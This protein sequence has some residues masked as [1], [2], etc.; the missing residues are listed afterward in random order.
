M[1]IPFSDYAALVQERLEK[2]YGIPV[3]TRD[4]PDPLTGDL[5]GAEIDID[6][7]TT[8]EQRLFLLGHLFG[9]TVQWDTD[10][11]SF[12]LG[13]QVQPPVDE[14]LFPAILAYEGEAGRY[15]LTLL[16]ESGVTSADVH[17]WFSNYTASDQAY[18]LDFYRS[19]AKHHDFK[20]FWRDNAPLVE[21]KPIPPFKPKKRVFRMDGV[22]I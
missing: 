8:P 20:S 14:K 15:G 18:L 12:E 13:K 9:H 4:I 6:Y 10:P 17:Q 22:V 7:L 3:I 1:A 21:P 11:G 19:G 16:R 5:D 2:V